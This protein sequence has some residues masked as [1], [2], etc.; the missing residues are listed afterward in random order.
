LRPGLLYRLIKGLITSK[1]KNTSLLPKYI[2]NLKGIVTGG[3][4]TSIYRDQIEHYWGRKPLEVYGATEIGA[5]ASQAWNFKGLTFAPD[6]SFLEFIPNDEYL[7]NK[8][9]PDYHPKS[10][11]LN[12]LELGIYEIVCTNLHGGIFTRYRVGDL[13]EVISLRDDEINVNL[14]QIRFYSRAGDMINLA[15]M[16]L[17]TEKNIWEAIEGAEI[18]YYDWVARKELLDGKIYLRLFIELKSPKNIDIDQT[19][20]KISESLKNI[21]PDYDG[22]ESMLGYDPLKLDLLNPGAFGAYMDYQKSEGA[23]LAHTKPPHMK[24]TSEQMNKL[25]GGRRLKK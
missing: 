1:I 19:K 22:F 7:K 11:T 3:T 8:E 6:M 20:S 15:G 25:L 24:P 9:D 2:W 4:D 21:N 10:I 14:P 5:V 23:D 13:I 16:A 18:D 12:E 17:L